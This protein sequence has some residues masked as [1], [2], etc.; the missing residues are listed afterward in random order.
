MVYMSCIWQRIVIWI[1]T[2]GLYE[3]YL[4]EVVIW[5]LT[6]GLYELYL[7]EDYFMD[8]NRWFI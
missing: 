8:S 4:V 1:L 7:V 3:L 5:I 2:D 6:Y